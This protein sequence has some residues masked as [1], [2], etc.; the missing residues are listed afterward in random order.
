M[1]KENKKCNVHH[2]AVYYVLCLF[3]SALS[4]KCQ[5][6][7]TGASCEQTS[8]PDQCLTATTSVYMG[9]FILTSTLYVV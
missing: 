5:Q 6:C 7:V 1:N 4:L 2:A 8:C 9:K 3:S